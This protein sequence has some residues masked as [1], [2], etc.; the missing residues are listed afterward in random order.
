MSQSQRADSSTRRLVDS[1]THRLP[2]M[3]KLQLVYVIIGLVVALAMILAML[4][5]GR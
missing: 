5:I 2:A 3:T 4:P 1:S